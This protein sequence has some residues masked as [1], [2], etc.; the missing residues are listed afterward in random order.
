MGEKTTSLRVQTL[1]LFGIRQIQS[2]FLVLAFQCKHFGNPYHYRYLKLIVFKRLQERVA[3]QAK[4]IK[5]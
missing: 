5:P 1:C 3:I 4:L 2:Y